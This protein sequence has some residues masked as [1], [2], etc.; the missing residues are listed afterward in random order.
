MSKKQTVIV[1][2]GYLGFQEDDGFHPHIPVGASTWFAWLANHKGF[3]YQ[4]EVGRFTAR[5][6]QIK[7]KGAYWYAYRRHGKKVRKKYLGK[8]AKLT[9]QRLRQIAAQLAETTG[10]VAP[11]ALTSEAGSPPTLLTLEGVEASL[12]AIKFIPPMRPIHLINRSRL[13]ERLNAPITYVSAPAGYGKSTL[14]SQWLRQAQL[15]YIWIGL[16]KS[17]DDPVLFWQ[18]V[19]IAIRKV[20]P[21]V[22]PEVGLSP[23]HPISS[24]LPELIDSIQ[25]IE[26]P[27]CLVL[28]DFH[29][30]K[31][32]AIQA[33]VALLLEHLPQQLRVVF[34]SRTQAPFNVGRWRAKGRY[35]EL[36]AGELRLTADEGVAYLAQMTD[37]NRF[38]MLVMVAQMEGWVTGLQL[39]SLALRHQGNVQEY[40]ALPDKSMAYFQTYLLEDILEH[41]AAH[42]QTFLMQIAILGT[43]NIE[44]CNAVTGQ[45][46]SAT[47]LDYMLE[48]NLFITAVPWQSGWYRL[49]QVFADILGDQLLIRLP[50]Q[51]NDLHLRAARWYKAAGTTE[52]AVYHLLAAQAWDEAAAAIEENTPT[53]FM[54]GEVDRLLRWLEGLPQPIL[55]NHPLLMMTYA[56]MC[57]LGQNSEDSY[58]RR[59][60]AMAMDA[61]QLFDY[62]AGL[63]HALPVE[64]ERDGSQPTYQYI[65]TAIDLIL[66]SI[67]DRLAGDRQN[68]EQALDQVMTLG[69]TYGHSYITFQAAG[70]LAFQ[71]VRQGRLRQ[72]EQIINQLAQQVQ[73]PISQLS[74]SPIIAQGMVHYEHNQLDEAHDLVTAILARIGG[75]NQGEV[76]LRLRWLL[77]A[78]LVGLRQT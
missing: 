57:R 58:P 8:T 74:S 64:K 31:N 63:E 67:S 56:R 62:L 37:L 76:S 22:L 30:I 2:N 61:D 6:E 14:I 19:V 33:D 28:E 65:W 52:D 3:A 23:V 48:E 59:N 50:D 47:L 43:L 27:C 68:A 9:P 69:A 16:D 44:L 40:L 60:D 75:Q 32:K 41:E 5:C 39:V 21:Q 70:I 17:D 11:T 42:V 66:R 54:R 26:N 73:S 46:N 36:D 77:A 51:V 13:T 12:L 18:I 4:D 29:H 35:V 15:P 24:F 20:L 45:D 78:D 1:T 10:T 34:T 49:H 71:H 55:H 38:E 53:L 72:G 7:G 25:Q